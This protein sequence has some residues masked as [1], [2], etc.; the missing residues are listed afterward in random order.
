METLDEARNFWQKT[1][2]ESNPSPIIKEEVD[3]VIKTRVKMEQKN[4]AQYFWLSFVFQIVIYSFACYLIIKYWGDGRMMTLSAAGILLYIPLTI[5]LMKKFQTFFNPPPQ[6]FDIRTGIKN[7]YQSLDQFF[8][9]KKRFDLISIPLNSIIL[10]AILFKLYVPGGIEGH[11]AGAVMVC[12]G[13]LVI[14]STATWFENKKHFTKP[15]KRFR[16]ILEDIEKLN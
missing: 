13:M 6:I 14:Y 3:N 8:S 5:I 11:P 2:Q 4:A 9:F 1:N 16:F 12:L 10:T 7:Q 15:L